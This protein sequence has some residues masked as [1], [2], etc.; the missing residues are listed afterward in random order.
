M[1]KR[2]RKIKSKI[3]DSENVEMI[4]P[5]AK[6]QQWDVGQIR[7]L[8]LSCFAIMGKLFRK[9]RIGFASCDLWFMPFWSSHQMSWQKG[10]ND[11]SGFEES[12]IMFSLVLE[13][14]VFI[15]TCKTCHIVLTY[16]RPFNIPLVQGSDGLKTH[17]AS[18]AGQTLSVEFANQAVV[19]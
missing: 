16:R 3:W 13:S 4:K 19:S 5:A 6:E 10:W 14:P 17:Q 18:V 1:K 7:P 2:L 9:M 12:H 15:Y 11:I 8:I